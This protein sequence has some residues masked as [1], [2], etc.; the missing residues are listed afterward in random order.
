MESVLL[1]EYYNYEEVKNKLAL[2]STL[3]EIW[4]SSKKQFIQ[5][6]DHELIEEELTEEQEE[7]RY[8]PYLKFDGDKA[9]ANNYVGFI[10]NGEQVIE[11]Y[12]KVFIKH[13]KDPEKTEKAEK[14]LM[15]R[16]IFYWFDGCRKWKFPFSEAS[17]DTNAIEKFP[18]LIIKLIANQFYSAITEQPL[19]MYQQVEEAI[20]SPR[21]SINFKRYINS[22]IATGNFQKIECDYEQFLFDNKV[23][24]AIK[25][26]ARLLL[27]QT[28]LPENITVLQE[29]IF[30][31]DEVEDLPCTSPEIAKVQI[32]PFFENYV[33]VLD[34]CKLIL[35]QK[36]YSTGEYDLS[37][38]C[39]LFPMEYIF[40]EFLYGF[41]QSNFSNEWDVS[42][43]AS[44]KY[45]AKN[46]K[47]GDVF[48]MK[49]DILLESKSGRKIIIDAKYKVRPPDFKM[50]DKKGI[51]QSDLYQMTSYAL[52]RGCT[53]VLLI[54]PNVT[55]KQL[56]EKDVFWI[57]S[58][59]DKP[60]KNEKIKFKITAVEIPFW[61]LK[62]FSPDKLNKSIRE[63]LQAHLV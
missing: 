63:V 29:I 9:K 40:E 49:H 7:G 41:I 51:D 23:N 2:Q 6:E 42:P 45:L 54:Y 47:E 62:D 18:E 50:K 20:T 8:Q 33:K 34:S 25:Y 17:L 58:G 19:S 53:E 5:L 56:F 48:R 22:S 35:D 21:G 31:L 32:N 38:W 60:K 13:L 10:Q 14:E 3:K 1:F 11:I 24:R 52:R 15:L 46:E 36:L 44:E 26:C 59:F 43:Q 4:S 37:Q 61:S 16:H 28:R 39:L 30:V 12:P 55:D 57:E 27:S